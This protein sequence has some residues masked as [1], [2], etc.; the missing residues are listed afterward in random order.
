MNPQDEFGHPVGDHPAWSESYYFNCVDP[1]Q[2]ICMVT[3]MSFRANDGYADG[4]HVVFLEGNRILFSF[5]R[6][7]LKVDD[8]ELKVHGLCFERGEPF[9]NWTV[10]YEGP[11]MDMPDGTVLL[12]PKNER[13]ADWHKTS[14]LN[15]TL[16]FETLSDPHYTGRG[17]TGHFE[18][19]CVSKGQIKVGEKSWEIKGFGVRDKSWG[20]R[21]WKPMADS[22]AGD[23]QQQQIQ[24]P[25]PFVQWF[26]MNFGPDLALGFV[27]INTPQGEML[28][29]AG[30]FHQE[31]K[32]REMHDIKVESRYKPDSIQ[33][34]TANITGTTDDGSTVEL[35]CQV[36]SICPIEFPMPEGTTFVL[37][38]L[39]RFI[40]DGRE[41]YGI[42]EYWHSQK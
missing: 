42:A 22:S 40:L 36:L 15:L 7:D 41:G 34:A 25:T 13:P 12:T 29:N 18:Q 4:L 24:G 11:I 16:D 35:D 10:S 38:G 8:H 31:G 9:K 37:E 30:W 26:S 23:S 28:H 32:T 2:K 6:R 1:D 33:H 27:T 17:E 3:R 21:D 19:T 5:N 14:H 39:A 20:P